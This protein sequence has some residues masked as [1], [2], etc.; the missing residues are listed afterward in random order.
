MEVANKTA[1]EVS[2]L[3]VQLPLFYAEEPEVVCIGRN[4]S[5]PCRQLGVLDHKH[6]NSS[7][8]SCWKWICPFWSSSSNCWMRNYR[9]MSKCMIPVMVLSMKKKGPYS[10]SR[11]T[12]GFSLPQILQLW[13]LSI[14]LTWMLSSLKIKEFRNLSSPCVRWVLQYH[15]HQTCNVLL[16]YDSS[17]CCVC[18]LYNCVCS[19][20]VVKLFLKLPVLRV[21]EV[22]LFCH[23]RIEMFCCTVQE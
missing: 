23:Q 12:H 18:F 21:Y 10:L 3:T 9:G 13:V 17:K 16:H 1:A 2:R 8:P 15:I 5:R 22:L 20:K 7:A 19:F 14:P 4:I 6:C 11:E